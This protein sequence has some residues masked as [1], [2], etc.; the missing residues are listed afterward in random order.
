MITLAGLTWTECRS[1]GDRLLVVPIGSTEQHGPHLPLDTDTDLAQALAGRLAR[2]RPDVLVAPTLPYGA[3]GEHGGFAGTLSI[4]Q[5]ALEHVLIELVRSAT[6]SFSRV[7]LLSGHGGNAEPVQR[8]V[9]LLRK[10]SRDVRGWFPSWQGDAHAGR[11]ETSLQLALGA[12]RVRLEFAERGNVAPLPTLLPALRA[13]GVRSVSPNGVLGDPAGA[14]A[15]EGNLLLDELAAAIDRFVTDWI[16][17]DGRTGAA[18][19]RVGG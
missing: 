6:D 14:T 9:A 15:A 4:G 2:R 1:L 10:E 16:G 17:D 19:R 3:S 7:L 11:V 18:A 12:S 8:A 5:Q 13:G